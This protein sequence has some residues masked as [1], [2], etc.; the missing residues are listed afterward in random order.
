MGTIYHSGTIITMQEV[1]AGT[2][3][4]G[5]SP[6]SVLTVDDRIIATGTL[7]DIRDAHGDGHELVDLEGNVLLP[8]FVDAHSH[9][10][11]YGVFASQVNLRLARSVDDIVVALSEKLAAR[12][13]DDTTPLAGVAYDHNN[14]PGYRHPDRHDLDRVSDSV[15]IFII[16]QS[17]HMGV[18]NSA[19][20]RTA[21]I[22]ASTPDPD[23]GR[24]GRE[25]GTSEPDG[26]VEELSA[27]MIFAQ[28]FADG[29]GTSLLLPGTQADPREAIRTA[30][31]EY[32]SRGITTVQEGAAA[33]HEVDSLIAAGADG[34]LV[35]DVVAYPIVTAGGLDVL[36]AHPDHVGG[37]VDH[38]RLAAANSFWTG[39]RRRARRGCPS[40]TS[41]SPMSRSQGRRS[42]VR[43]SVSA[44]TRPFPT[45][46]SPDTSPGRWR[47][48]T[49]SWRT[50]TATPPP[51]NS[52]PPTPRSPRPTHR[53]R[54][55]DPS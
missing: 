18:A 13:E 33:P 38:V 26:Y 21:G 44:A 34:D 7:E 54:S 52:S 39:H 5:P 23:G 9:F 22:D 1:S 46:R 4:P 29:A 32:L 10:T 36:D 35:L 16:H 2:G 50:A 12:A 40:P 27:L 14:L 15:P 53:P 48:A 45:T 8:A 31:R 37:Y 17:S 47:A 11:T 20:L 24:F 42:T 49:R 43:A 51:S 30:Q 41:P 25:S 28:G 19:A 3:A 6:E 55:C